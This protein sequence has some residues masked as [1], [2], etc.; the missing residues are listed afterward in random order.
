MIFVSAVL[1]AIYVSILTNRLTTTISTEMPPKLLAAGLPA[2]SIAEFIG[3][4]SVGTPDAFAAVPGVTSEIIA[5][6]TRAYKVANAHA[7][8]TVYLSTIAFSGLA[9]ILTWFAPNTDEFMSEK[10]AATLAGEGL[11]NKEDVKH[12]ETA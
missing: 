1:V 12:M 7:Y 2:T 5:I 9:I 6:G 11:D 4:F 10:V 3:A 8:S